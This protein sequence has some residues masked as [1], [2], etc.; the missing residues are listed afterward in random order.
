MTTTKE[1]RLGAY[2]PS[3]QEVRW[4]KRWLSE[5]CYAAKADLSLPK[6]Y[7]LDMFP[8]P[9]GAGLH[10]GHPLS[11]TAT[12]ILA[13]FKRHRGFNVLHPMGWD[14]FGLPAEQYALKT[15]VHPAKT[16]AANVD[17]FRRQL[18]ALGFS[19]EWG[20]EVNTTDPSYYRW[21]QWIFL[22]LFEK[23]LA[24]QA[25]MP[26]NWCPAMGTVLANEEVV[27]GKSEVGGH[28]VIRRPMKQWM[29]KITAYADRLLEGLDDLAWP[30][31]VKDMQRNWI[32]R[33]VGAEID[34]AVDGVTD[35]AGEPLNLR[36]FTTR[37]DTLFGATYMVIAPEHKEWERLVSPEQ[38]AACEDYRAAAESKSDLERTALQRDKTGVPTGRFA[39][40]PATGERIPIWMAD[41]VM[42]G[43]GT[44]AIM[45]VPCGDERDH[46]FASKFELPIVQVVTPTDPDA[47]PAAEA[48]W[49]GAG[50][51][52]NS[53]FLDGTSTAE[54]KAKMTAWLE[55]HGHGHAAV[56]TKL[57]DWLFSRQRYWGEPFPLL[58]HEDGSVSTVPESELP[59]TLPEVDKYEPTGTGES[60]L[61]VVSDW[62]NT[63]DPV[64][65]EPVKR[66]T[67]T[68]P[69]WAG[70]C[71]YY[72]RY[73]DPHNEQQLVSP[74]LEKYWMPVDLY[75]GGSEHAVLHLL[76]A[77][78]WHKVLFDAGVVSTSEP[79]GKLLNQGM[80]LGEDGE[81]MSKSRG[82]V[83][84]PDDMVTKY[85]ADA[86]RLYE[87]FMGPLTA[88][89]PWQTSG[90]NGTH[91]FLARA[92]R[93][94]VNDDGD[95]V[96]SDE[97]ASDTARRA[98]AATLDK[99][100]V[101]TEALSFNTAISAMMEFVNVLTK[102]GSTMPRELAHD[103]AVMLE[104][105]APHLAEELNARLG[106]DE[107]LAWQPWPE[108]DASLLVADTVSV[109][110]QV[111]GKVRTV[112][113]LPE[114]HDAAA[115]EAA[116]RADAGVARLIEQG[117]VKKV[118]AVPGRILNFVVAAG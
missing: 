101:D 38:R 50:T 16:T 28:E 87:M 12:D 45:A 11:Y 20:R 95:F 62:V 59:V 22:K 92:W 64:S 13:R 105:Y 74:E 111:N 114:G 33:S 116:G 68:M 41:Y 15:G 109:P 102:E 19:Y 104:P 100:T 27:D 69:Q 86:F 4:Q 54:S 75:I 46:E 60:P 70:S 5:D 88:T 117:T 107:L 53:G 72:L 47:P 108:A 90:L 89:K 78:F 43:Y 81:K 115:L 113:E 110:V 51:M 76:Y 65:G 37:P 82:N 34:F 36:V 55:E 66:E 106:S 52:V 17:N 67:H 6:Y 97:P 57:R 25:E 71:W 35:A 85:G 2:D 29:L 77:R 94:F 32:G 48:A 56:H 30:E 49:T 96:V 99:V 24:Y 44:G 3:A 10:V 79:F 103:F 31:H 42:V 112:L 18:Q 63:T 83:I 80:I 26:V 39:I 98:W 118:V 1:T 58:H 84:N 91:R 9:S 14:A 73:L 8:Y 40:N 23:G 21:T 93:L 7:V 61:A